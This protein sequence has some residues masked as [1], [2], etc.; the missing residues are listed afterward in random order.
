MLL[1]FIGIKPLERSSFE[2]REQNDYA[3]QGMRRVNRNWNVSVYVLEKERD[4]S[5]KQPGLSKATGSFKLYLHS[6]L[7]V[8]LALPL[9]RSL[10]GRV[11]D[12]LRVLMGTRERESQGLSCHGNKPI[13]PS[14]ALPECSRVALYVWMCV[15]LCE[16]YQ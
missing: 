7:S 6:P 14:A 15:C 5:S 1:D 9:F 12:G 11:I 10:A 16:S 3:K 8:S 13:G 4:S 2:Q